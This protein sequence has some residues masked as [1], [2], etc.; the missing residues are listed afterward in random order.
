MRGIIVRR[1]GLH[2]TNG[3]AGVAFLTVL[4]VLTACMTLVPACRASAATT[5]TW[6]QGYDAG[7]E[8]VPGADHVS[9]GNPANWSPQ[10]V[11]GAGDTVVLANAPAYHGNVQSSTVLTVPSG[12]TSA[13]LVMS[14]GRAGSVH[15]AGAP[16]TITGRF[17]W[18]GGELDIPVTLGVSA[19]GAIGAGALKILR[20]RLSVRGS[21][22]LDDLGAD[23]DRGL[24]LYPDY[25]GED[26]GITIAPGGTLSAVGTNLLSGTGCCTDPA[27][28]RSDGTIHIQSGTTTLRAVELDLHGAARVDKGALLHHTV[29]FARL[30][31]GVRYSGGGTLDFTE[32]AA[33]SSHPDRDPV[34]GGIL[35][36]GVG[37]LTDQTR[38]HL[39][40]AAKLTGVGGFAG[41]GVVDVSAAANTGQQSAHVYA[42]LTIGAATRLRLG[43]AVP[44]SLETWSPTLPGYRGV[45]RI[46]GAADLAAGTSF[47]TQ[48]GTVTQVAQGG[49][50][51]LES[52]STWGGG[53]CCLNPARLDVGAGGTLTIGSG[54]QP[55]LVRVDLR[56]AGEI[57]LPVGR[58][59]LTEGYPVRLGGTLRLSGRMKPSQRRTVVTAQKVTGR[60]ACVRPTGQVAIYTATAMKVSGVLGRYVGCGVAAAG[61]KLAVKRVRK[62]RTATVKVTRG[63]SK[64]AGKVLL[65]VTVTKVGR[66]ARIKVG[67]APA[68]RAARGRS[69]TRYVVA[70]R[71]KHKLVTVRNGGTKAVKIKIVLL[72]AA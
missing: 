43:G 9:W 49:T 69:T 20:H 32:T 26:D 51:R 63:I 13:G 60:F 4:V 68:F 44:S 40:V 61:K 50:L 12:T 35:M 39:G 42:D 2:R 11:P 65:A 36:G 19:T 67:G 14:A 34:P 38:I 28:I 27:R 47:V 17:T 71:K 31:A 10:G 21:L 23:P 58:Q 22:L 33:V 29:G 3:S 54:V 52:G 5:Y 55:R 30:G 16:L 1:Q 57:V 59:L 6:V 70:K 45:L 56:T 53:D 24:D 7:G 64:K 25:G 72:G 18:T 41:A 37:Q 48:G 15:L 46:G 8:T 62:H 66:A